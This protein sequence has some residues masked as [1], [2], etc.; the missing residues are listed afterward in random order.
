MNTSSDEGSIIIF[1]VEG[2]NTED[3]D[4]HG[5]Y[6][7]LNLFRGRKRTDEKALNAD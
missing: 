3:A 2:E 5:T 1:I 6:L 4:A 7:R